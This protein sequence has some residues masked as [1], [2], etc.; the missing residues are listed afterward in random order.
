MREAEICTD[1]K[2][3]EAQKSVNICETVRR[4]IP[5][6]TILHVCYYINEQIDNKVPA[7]VYLAKVSLHVSTL[8]RS[9]SSESTEM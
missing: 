9:S 1:L 8:T 6:E 7:F 5:Q 2:M 4:H 3:E